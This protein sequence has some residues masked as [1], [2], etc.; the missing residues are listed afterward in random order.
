[1]MGLSLAITAQGGA[2]AAAP[3]TIQSA[4]I[5]DSNPDALYVQF[6]TPV[7]VVDETDLTITGTGGPRGLPTVTGVNHSG[8]FSGDFSSGDFD[9]GSIIILDLSHPAVGGETWTLDVGASNTITGSGG[10]VDADT[11][12][13]AQDGTFPNDTIAA[14]ISTTG[15]DADLSEEFTDADPV[16][17][18]TLRA[19]TA[20]YGSLSASGTPDRHT[21]GDGFQGVNFASER[22]VSS[23]AAAIW[24]FLHNGDGCSIYVVGAPDD[25]LSATYAL[26]GTHDGGTGTGLSM[27]CNTTSQYFDCRVGRVGAYYN[28]TIQGAPFPPNN[29]AGFVAGQRAVMSYRVSSAD[30]GAAEVDDVGP[31]TAANSGS[32][33]TGD[34]VSTLVIGGASGTSLPYNGKIYRVL[35]LPSFLSTTNDNAIVDALQEIYG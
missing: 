25:L 11:E 13:V 3:P 17:A 9:D 29:P 27:V 32:P 6:T 2:V 1:M 5:Y 24:R 33:Q 4:T 22:L 31:T 18:V 34:P 20:T 14:L 28:R 23:A 35:I 15:F 10:G 7:E 16:T 12:A 21:D 8:D 19:G 30:N 26:L